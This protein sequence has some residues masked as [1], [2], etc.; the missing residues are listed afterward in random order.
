MLAVGG[1]GVVL[2]AQRAAGADLG[3]L[4]AEQAGPQ[5]E[6]ALALQRGGLGV[7]AADQHQVAVEPAQLLV[8]QR[9]D[10]GVVLRVRDALALGVEQL[11][12]LRP[13]VLDGAFRGL[14]S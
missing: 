8:G 2:R 3:G 6:L 10:D 4:L 14:G 12:H 7:E 13:A 9:V 1:E 5:A 11:D